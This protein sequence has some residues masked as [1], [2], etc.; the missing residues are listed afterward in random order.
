MRVYLRIPGAARRWAQSCPRQPLP[1]LKRTPQSR[2][3]GSSATKASAGDPQHRQHDG[4]VRGQTKGLRSAD[5]AIWKRNQK[6][7]LCPRQHREKDDQ[8]SYSVREHI[9]LPFSLDWFRNSNFRDDGQ[10][11][12]VVLVFE[13]LPVTWFFK[14]F[15]LSFCG[16]W[17]RVEKVVQAI[18][19]ATVQALAAVDAKLDSEIAAL[20]N[21]DAKGPRTAAPV[22]YRDATTS[23]FCLWI[24]S[25]FG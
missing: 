12:Y 14:P 1:P 16:R 23:R 13:L 15:L 11:R 17:W 4:S 3:Q 9:A 8:A 21:L 5:V 2:P 10:P 24:H 7:I 22:R 18:A 20:D 19:G 25:R 6:E